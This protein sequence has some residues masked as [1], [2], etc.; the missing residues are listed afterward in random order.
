MLELLNTHVLTQSQLTES[1]G[2]G[3]TYSLRLGV[4]LNQFQ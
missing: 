4:I 3:I 2:Q 1:I